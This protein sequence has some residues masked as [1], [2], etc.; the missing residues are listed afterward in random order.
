MIGFGVLFRRIENV[1]VSKRVPFSIAVLAFRGGMAAIVV[2]AITGAAEILGP[3]WSGLFA[4]FPITLFPLLL[5]MH[6]AYGTEPV[7]TI[8]KNFPIGLGS[9]IVYTLSVA[10]TYETYGVA[11]GTVIS[12]IIATGYLT[13]FTQVLKRLKA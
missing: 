3:A 9:L 1:N 5:V 7:H 12:F 13:L 11:L 2:I 10:F 4:G 6:L 8:I